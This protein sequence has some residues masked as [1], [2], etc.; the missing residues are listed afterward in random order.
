[1]VFREWF[2]NICGYRIW[3]PTHDDPRIKGL[4]PRIL[5]RRQWEMMEK[6][7]RER[8]IGKT[9]LFKEER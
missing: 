9:E 4:P 3:P 7:C 8:E 2:L 6:M 5:T 1:M